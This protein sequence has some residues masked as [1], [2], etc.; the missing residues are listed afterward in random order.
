[1][2]YRGNDHTIEYNEIFDVVRTGTDMGAVYTGRDIT[3]LGNV[4][5]FNYFH[6]IG[7]N[8]RG[9]G[10]QAIFLDDASSGVH[11]HGN[12]FFKAGSNAAIKYHGGTR[13]IAEN[14]I[15]IGPPPAVA[16]HHQSWGAAFPRRVGGNNTIRA[17]LGETDPKS[18]PWSERWPWLA[19]VTTDKTPPDSNRT[20]G[21]VIVNMGVASGTGWWSEERDNLVTKEDPGFVDFQNHN[22]ELRADSKAL[23]ELPA[24]QRPPFAKMGLYRD[25][26]T[27][28]LQSDKH[29]GTRDVR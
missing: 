29:P 8:N 4:I 21:N 20:S 23:R 12:V 19:T 24:F 15:F 25:E 22:F 17:R 6:D 26:Y 5:R 9:H 27:P 10:T 2:S 1:M 18:P 16:V 13:N 14:N 11:I 28:H 7:N 3:C